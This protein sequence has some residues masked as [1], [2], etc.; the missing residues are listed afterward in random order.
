ML[1]EGELSEDELYFAVKNMNKHKS[2][3]SDGLPAEFFI[4]FW[5]PLGK[6]YTNVVNTCFSNGMLSDSQRSGLITLFRKDQE[7]AEYMQNC[8]PISLLNVDYKIVSK[9]QC[10]RLKSFNGI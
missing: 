10:N 4:C 3:G 6:M 5:S 2:P 1:C 7:K 9:A 8:R